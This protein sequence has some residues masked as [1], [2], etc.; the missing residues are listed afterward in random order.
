MTANPLD[1]DKAPLSAL[2]AQAHRKAMIIMLALTT[3]IAV[4]AVLG[5]IILNTR[6]AA[7]RP[8]QA[9]IPF[10][11][12]ALFLAL[13]SIAFRRT[14]LRWLRLEVVGGL[15]GAEGVVK[16]FFNTALVSAVLAEA[17]GLL[18]LVIVFFG[19]DTR[20][21]LSLGIV[22]LL[23]V[24][25]SYPRRSDWEKAAEYFAADA[26]GASAR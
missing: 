20:D 1:S 10:F 26:P 12:A 2:V 19:G 7:P 22:A 8:V 25:T 3:S 9:R 24:L 6:D 11:V 5:L 14:Q 15:R 16:H 21:V 17:I 4:Y 23:I 13:G 18:A